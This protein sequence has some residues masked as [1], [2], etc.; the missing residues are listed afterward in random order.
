L[1]TT[2]KTIF[3]NSHFIIVDKAAMVLSVPSRLG[4]KDERPCLGHILE[5]DLKCQIFPVHRLD[6]EVQGLIMYAKTKEAHRSGNAWFENKM[7]EKTYVALTSKENKPV[8][9]MNEKFQWQCSL[10]RGKKRAYESPQG[11]KSITTGILIEQLSRGNYRWHLNP[12][13][14]RSHQLRF[15]L[16]RHGHPII[17]DELYGSSEKFSESGIALRAF[18]IN[19]EKISDRQKFELPEK[20]KISEF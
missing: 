13:T 3:E 2:Y 11:K 20:I 12:I 16:F 1:I 15:E 10:L 14:G 7:I 18:E 5:A 6:F 9:K 4:E 17:G 19:L 8:E